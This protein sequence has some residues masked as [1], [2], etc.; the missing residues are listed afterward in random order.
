MIE[1]SKYDGNGNCI[2]R[3][4]CLI[5][6]VEYNDVYSELCNIR[7]QLGCNSYTDILVFEFYLKEHHCYMVDSFCYQVKDLLL[8]KGRYIIFCWNRKDYYHM[9]PV[10]DGV[11]YDKS[12]D[13]MDLYIIKIY[14]CYD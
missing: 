12:S 10:I 3:S 2:I 1:F 7:D 4:F 6:N 14:R 13:C 9:I 5:F 11:I 8:D